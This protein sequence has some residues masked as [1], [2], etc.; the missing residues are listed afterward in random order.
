MQDVIEY[1]I[2][3]LF[4]SGEPPVEALNTQVAAIIEAR[5]R[6]TDNQFVNE[7]ALYSLLSRVYAKANRPQLH[8][9][10]RMMSV[11]ALWGCGQASNESCLDLSQDALKGYCGQVMALMRTILGAHP[12][13][14]TWCVQFRSRRNCHRQ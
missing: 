13:G 7:R 3:A 8:L 12:S 11:T 9:D 1:H 5:F 10:N 4:I 6:V 2:V 14:A